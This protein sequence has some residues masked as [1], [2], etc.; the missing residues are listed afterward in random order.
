MVNDVLHIWTDYEFMVNSIWLCATLLV[1]LCL[2]DT[3][4]ALFNLYCYATGYL[5]SIKL[6]IVV[7]GECY[8]GDLV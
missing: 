4:Y 6:I 7:Y 3:S 8:V 1:M 2:V 5:T